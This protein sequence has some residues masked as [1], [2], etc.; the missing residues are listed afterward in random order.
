MNFDIAETIDCCQECQKD[1]PFKHSTS[2]KLVEPKFAWHTISVD[3][4]GPFPTSVGNLK[5][6]IVAI[7]H[8][9]KWV[10]AQAI[11]DTGA[12]NA[13]RFILNRVMLR[14]GSP[15]FILSDNGTSFTAKVIPRLNELM[16]VRGV[17][18]TPYHPETNGMV[19][20][21][22]GTLVS[23]LRKIAAAKPSSWSAVLPAAVF[24]Y[25]IA[26]HSATGASPF[27]LLFG[28]HPALPPILYS[29]SKP[30]PEATYEQYL[31]TLT[32]TLIRLQAA[33]FTNVAHNKQLAYNRAQANL[34]PLPSFEVGESVSFCDT[35]GAGRAN[36]LASIWSGPF[37][38]IEKT[39][40]DAYTIKCN[41]TGRLI[42]RV[43][44][45]F[46]RTF[47]AMPE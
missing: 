18:S 2:F 9:T 35:H 43:H 28:R 8:L 10:K 33:A 32:D 46:L 26:Q 15:Q 21:V 13:A 34:P 40:T 45:K 25:N 5:F 16:G 20:R 3:I 11:T 30:V 7:D 12:S 17:L 38:I 47:K 22:N 29:V 39:S 37:T 44:A 27:Q 1:K 23:I 31:S 41:S 19:E 14:H 42:N 4:M 24:A 6:I 36:K